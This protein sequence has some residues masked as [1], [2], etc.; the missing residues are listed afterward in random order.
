M[1]GNNIV[2][3]VLNTRKMNAG[4]RKTTTYL[5]EDAPSVN[6]GQNS[7]NSQQK[8]SILCKC[9]IWFPKICSVIK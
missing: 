6:H 2:F 9:D 4:M 7:G 5:G 8:T 3:T 1:L